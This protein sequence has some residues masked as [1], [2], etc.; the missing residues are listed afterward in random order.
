MRISI[1]IKCSEENYKKRTDL[2][3]IT[4]DY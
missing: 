1:D 4:M 2:M 3:L